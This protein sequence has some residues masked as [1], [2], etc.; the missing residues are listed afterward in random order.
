M[1]LNNEIVETTAVLPAAALNEAEDNPDAANEIDAENMISTPLDSEGTDVG[2]ELGC[3]E[4]RD[5]GC[6]AGCEVG[7]DVG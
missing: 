3:E 5:E 1:P 7:C 6:L 2:S 4:G